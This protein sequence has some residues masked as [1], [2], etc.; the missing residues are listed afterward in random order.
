MRNNQYLPNEKIDL[1]NVN[2]RQLSSTTP[3]YNNSRSRTTFRSQSRNG[4]Y[5]NS[6]CK[7]NRNQQDHRN[8]YRNNND[9]RAILETIIIEVEL[10]ATTETVIITDTTIVDEIRDIQTVVFPGKIQHTTELITRIT[11]TIN[12]IDKE[13]IA[14]IQTEVIDI[15][16]DQIVTINII[17]TITETIEQVHQTEIK[18]KDTNQEI[19]VKTETVT[20]TTI[21]IE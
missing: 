20:I 4:F 16:I 12:I 7:N 9:R 10:I 14:K 13:T 15:D 17:L 2:G 21:K 1:N 6:I 18:T 19:A 5:N 11:T 3:V 8:S